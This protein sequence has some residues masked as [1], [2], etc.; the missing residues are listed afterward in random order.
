MKKITSIMLIWCLSMLFAE[1]FSGAS[2]MWYLNIGAWLL[3]FPLYTFHILFFLFIAV[4]YKKISIKHLYILGMIFAL[5]ESWITKVL[6]EWYMTETS[7][8]WLWTFMWLWIIEYPILVF[9][10]HPIFSFILPVLTYQIISNN[11][12]E[13]H[14]NILKKTNKKTYI[15]YLFLA[16]ISSFIAFGN[17]FDPISANLSVIWTL[18]LIIIFSYFSK[19][20]DINSLNLEKKWF[21][22]TTIYILLLYIITFFNLLPERIPSYFLAYFSIIISYIFFIYLF[23]K[24]KKI[25]N[26]KNNNNILYSKKDL[27]RFILFLIVMVNIVSIFQESSY[28]IFTISYLLFTIIWIILFLMILYN[29]FKNTKKL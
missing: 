17:Q 4:Y 23:K 7:W 16:M 29:T 2:Q 21:I 22:L 5:Y 27:Y 15:I 10:W 28:V 9:F 26:I 8:P 3:T 20:K 14:K 12:I 13:E 1:V 25:N 6:W 11:I 24:T 19:D 18:I